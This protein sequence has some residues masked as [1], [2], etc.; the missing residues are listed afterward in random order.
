MSKLFTIREWISIEDASKH[1]SNVFNEHVTIADILTLAIEDRIT[2]SIRFENSVA[3]R[4][5]ELSNSKIGEYGKDYINVGKGLI[6][7]LKR[8]VEYID[9]I[10]DLPMV[11]GELVC[12]RSIEWHGDLKYKWTISFDEFIVRTKTGD[13]C[14]LVNPKKEPEINSDYY[15]CSNYTFCYEMPSD[16]RIV[17]RTSVISNLIDSLQSKTKTAKELSN[18]SERAYRNII[19]AM[20]ELLKNPR[21][22]RNDDAA[23]VR[24]LVANY[25]DKYGISESNLNRKFPEAKRSLHSD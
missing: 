15:D 23:I 12:I 25:G 20:L 9:D 16:S 6:L 24:E 1:L 17:L 5:G 4:K 21:D 3:V 2:L 8:N 14:A 13:Y 11:G 18:A 10:L 22:G 19:G 7:A